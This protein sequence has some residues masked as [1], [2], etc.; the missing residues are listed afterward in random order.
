MA[1]FQQWQ[2]Q[3]LWAAPG[4]CH[5]AATQDRRSCVTSKVCPHVIKSRPG[6]QLPSICSAATP[7][8]K[9]ASLAELKSLVQRSHWKANNFNLWYRKRFCSQADNSCSLV[10]I[11]WSFVIMMARTA[12]QMLQILLFWFINVENYL[13][14]CHR[15]NAKLHIHCSPN[16]VVQVDFLGYFSFAFHVL[17]T[18]Y[19]TDQWQIREGRWCGAMHL[20]QISTSS[21]GEDNNPG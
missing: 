21:A 17:I 12:K 19:F 2:G 11:E 4:C 1:P 16:T 20:P 9:T 13:S 7:H 18:E 5:A 10:L 14:A 3:V 8:S 15:K 6:A